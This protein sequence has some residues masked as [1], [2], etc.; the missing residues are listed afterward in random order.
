MD[1]YRNNS[2]GLYWIKVNG[3]DILNNQTRYPELLGPEYRSLRNVEVEQAVVLGDPALGM[4]IS[5]AKFDLRRESILQAGL[6][7]GQTCFICFI[8]GCDSARPSAA[9]RSPPGRRHLHALPP[10]QRATCDSVDRAT[11]T[12]PHGCSLPSLRLGAMLFSRD[13]NQLVLM[14]LEKIFEKMSRFAHDPLNVEWIR[15]EETQEAGDDPGRFEMKL[16]DDTFLKLTALMVV[17]AGYCGQAIPCKHHPAPHGESPWSQHR[18]AST[19]TRCT[20]GRTSSTL[21]HRTRHP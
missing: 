21:T 13:A 10:F 16:I 14:P 11:K 19:R 17:R 9:A 20:A 1:T 5:F 3:S 7:I 6:N 4:D 12:E 18:T 2:R 15:P 8:L